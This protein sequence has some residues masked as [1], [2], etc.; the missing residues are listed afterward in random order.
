MKKGWVGT[1]FF[2]GSLILLLYAIIIGI[3]RIFR[4]NVFLKDY[5]AKQLLLANEKRQNRLYRKQLN[6]MQDD[7]YWELEARKR[8]HDVKPG[9][10]VYKFCA[11]PTQNEVLEQ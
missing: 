2:I 8:L 10:I 11:Q 6:Q 3:K 9:E 7:Q 4:Y 5:Q 1:A